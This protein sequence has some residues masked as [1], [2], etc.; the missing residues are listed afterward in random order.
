MK[1]INSIDNQY[2]GG[3]QTLQAENHSACVWYYLSVEI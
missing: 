3:G 2:I 1:K